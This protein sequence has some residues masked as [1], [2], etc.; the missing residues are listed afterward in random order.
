V[1]GFGQIPHREFAMAHG[2][3]S[4]DEFTN[5]LMSVFTLLVRYCK[6]GSIHFV[7]SDWRH[8]LQMLT[9][10]LGVYTSYENLCIWRKKVPVWALFIE[11]RTNWCS[12]SRAVMH[13]I[14]TMFS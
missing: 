6:A 12:C 7:C 14:E 1:S 8:L 3:M 4:D 13:R 11:A 9:A 2:E 10:G 5:F